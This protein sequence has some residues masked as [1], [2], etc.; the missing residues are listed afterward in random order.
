MYKVYQGDV[1]SQLQEMASESVNCVVTSPPYW[2]LRNYGVAGQ[3]GQEPTPEE[4]IDKMVSIFREVR[5]VLKK[6]GNVWLNLGDSYCGTGDKGNWRDPKYAEGRNGQAKA[7][8]GKIEGLKKKDL[9]GIP[10][11]VALALQADGWYLRSDII[12]HKPNAMPSSVT[13]R[14]TTAHEYIFLLT[15]SPKYY[16]DHEAIKEPAVTAA[17]TSKSTFGNRGGELNRLHSGNTWKPTM[18][19]LQDKGQTNH[20]MHERRLEQPDKEYVVRNKR[21]VW[22]VNTKPYK[23]AHFATFP[24]DLIEPCV[25]AGCPVGGTVMDIFSGAATTG[26]AALKN[27]R[28]YLGIELNPDYIIIGDKRVEPYLQTLRL[29]S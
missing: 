10:W 7:L 16:Y 29:P 3:I 9:V 15:K 26:V 5:R 14:P 22:S 20:S 27:G 21:S 24:V 11:R 2:G 28:N 4:Y 19:N 1:L 6:D 23:E 12:W 25:L 8:N 17:N 18:K 13:D